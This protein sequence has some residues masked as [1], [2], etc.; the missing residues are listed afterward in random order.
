MKYI[1]LYLYI[2]NCSRCKSSEVDRGSGERWTSTT[3]FAKQ[4]VNALKVAM[5]LHRQVEKEATTGSY[6]VE[7]ESRCFA[8]NWYR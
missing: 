2:N 1:F 7:Y 4:V 8:I 6:G 5:K 3:V